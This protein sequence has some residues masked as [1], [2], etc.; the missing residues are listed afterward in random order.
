MW[1]W[2]ASIQRQKRIQRNQIYTDKQ[3]QKIKYFHL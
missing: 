3:Q 2:L 1:D